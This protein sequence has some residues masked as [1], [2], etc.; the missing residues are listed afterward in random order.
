M[1]NIINVDGKFLEY[2]PE[3]LKAIE[4]TEKN[5]FGGAISNFSKIVGLPLG[6]LSDTMLSWRLNNWL[7]ILQEVKTLAEKNGV[8]LRITT[9]D[10]LNKAGIKLFAEAPNERDSDLQALWAKLIIGMVNAANNKESD[11]APYVEIVKNLTAND[12]KILQTLFLEN[13]PANKF[14]WDKF[15]LGENEIMIAISRLQDN[16]TIFVYE[17]NRTEFLVTGSSDDRYMNHKLFEEVQI[18][19]KYVV[20]EQVMF[21]FL[22]IG[23]ELKKLLD[24]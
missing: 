16:K 14:P 11:K 10:W 13:N 20:R 18:Q 23:N 2:L 15:E 7:S 5:L 12:A 6:Y 17:E 1:I 21:R 24:C 9:P 4:A 22:P 8:K 3:A 19:D